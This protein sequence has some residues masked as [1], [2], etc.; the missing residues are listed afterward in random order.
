MLTRRAFLAALVPTT[1]WIQ[2]GFN[3]DSMSKGITPST[4]GHVLA[5]GILNAADHEIVEGYASVGQAKGLTI[6][7]VPGSISHQ[8]L[9][10]YLGADVDVV[11][12]LYQRNRP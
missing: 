7:S 5:M 4:A 12:R 1:D 2:G 9:R 6:M 11:I 8:T 10:D 3:L